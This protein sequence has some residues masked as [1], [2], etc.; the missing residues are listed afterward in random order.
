MSAVNTKL[1]EDAELEIELDREY[2]EVS[3]E[4]LTAGDMRDCNTF[5][6]PEKVSPVKLEAEL[7]AN[8]VRVKLPAMCIAAITLK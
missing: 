2:S 1:D 6:E 5:E 7:C 8:K 4:L 3:A